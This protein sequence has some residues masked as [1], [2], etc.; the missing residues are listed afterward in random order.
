MWSEDSNF[1]NLTICNVF[2][3]SVT[4]LLCCDVL[5]LITG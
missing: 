2:L 4:L 5:R 3:F 1:C